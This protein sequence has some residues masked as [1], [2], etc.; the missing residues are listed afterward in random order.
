MAETT[1]AT[2]AGSC[3]AG[4]GWASDQASKRATQPRST[5]LSSR[6]QALSRQP[7]RALSPCTSISPARR[8]VSQSA[9]T[10]AA[11]R[12]SSRAA[13][14]AVASE[15]VALPSAVA[16]PRPRA[17]SAQR[18]TRA[19]SARPARAIL[20]S[21]D[22]AGVPSGG[23]G[24]ARRGRRWVIAC[25]AAARGR[26]R[27]SRSLESRGIRDVTGA[28]FRLTVRK[29][30]RNAVSPV[31]D[32]GHTGPEPLPGRD[33]ATR[34]A[35]NGTGT[36]RG[37]HPCGGA[38]Y[39]PGAGRRAEGGPRGPAEAARGLRGQTSGVMKRR[40]VSS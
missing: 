35:L 4:S 7:G 5:A 19:A 1:S 30:K 38:A 23:R 14:S 25:G 15:R 20:A 28:V 29:P 24:A 10:S 12:P 2:A 3:P 21:S 32:R 39:A 40:S 8:A 36:V 37:C 33:Q 34:T 17:A 16:L 6:F 22:R 11:V 9:R 26:G 13:R 18:A 27:T 31:R